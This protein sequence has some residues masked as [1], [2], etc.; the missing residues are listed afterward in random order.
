M[1]LVDKIY[2]LRQ[3]FMV[4]GLT[5]RTGSGCSTVAKLLMNDFQSLF[6]PIPATNSEGVD[7]NERKYRI[8]Y[9]FLKEIWETKKF[10]FKVIRASDIIFYFVLKGSFDN[11][12]ES[13]FIAHKEKANESPTALTEKKGLFRD[14]MNK[15]RGLFNKSSDMIK[16]IDTYLNGKGYETIK[17]ERNSTAYKEALDYIAYLENELP[18]VRKILMERAT[19]S[20]KG[21]TTKQFQVWGN[22]IRKYG[23]ILPQ[24]NE[25]IEPSLLAETINKII[26]LYRKIS[27]E[28]NKPAFIIIDSLRNPFEVFYFRERYSAFYLMS[29]NTSD[30]NRRINLANAN[31]R[32]DEI[33]ALD[34]MEYPSKRK[35]ISTSYYSQ[36]VEQCVELSD[37][38]VAHDNKEVEQNGDLKKQLIHFISLILHPGLVL[39]THEERLM[40]IANTAKLNS[41]CI[42][43]QVGAVVTDSN[44]SVKS[45]GWNTVPQGQTPC[46]LRTLDDLYNRSDR[47]AFSDYENNDP[48][49]RLVVNQYHNQYFNSGKNKNLKGLPLSYCFKDLYTVVNKGMKN[50]VHTRSLHAEENSFLQLA[51]YGSDGIEGG[52]LFTTASPCE[53]CAKKAYQLGIKKIF[54]IDI[55]PGIST[56]HI[57]GCGNNRPEMVQFQGAIGRAY[58]ALYNPFFALK[59]EIEYLTDIKVKYLEQA[60]PKEMKVNQELGKTEK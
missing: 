59:D 34:D 49:F 23:N 8:E 57:L 30:K 41:G 4:I 28:E 32:K 54:Y 18:Q 46:S 52:F 40:Q 48:A 3:S 10:K 27:K 38:H 11:F 36:D 51:K 55:Y 17:K 47:N 42:S 56:T 2:N 24:D 9:N 31:Y 5:G 29:I 45:I 50:Q 25:A 13:F 19:N 22:N 14:N 15:I 58:E 43:R 20:L 37:I 39:P 33:E 44:Y 26:K 60:V 1:E 21:M 7:N 53:L 12:I 16:S 35:G 6:A